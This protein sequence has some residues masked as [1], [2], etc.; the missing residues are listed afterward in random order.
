VK[1]LV[2]H[3]PQEYKVRSTYRTRR[4][5]RTA[6]K[7]SCVCSLEIG[8][9][10]IIALVGDL[11]E[12]G[13]ISI[14]GKGECALVGLAAGK[15]SV[16]SFLKETLGSTEEKVQ[17]SIL[18]VHLVWPCENIATCIPQGSIPVL[19][20]IKDPETEKQKALLESIKYHVADVVFS[21]YCSALAV[22]T[23]EQRGKGVIVC[24][25]GGDIVTYAAFA[26]GKLLAVDAFKI[27][28]KADLATIKAIHISA[29]GAG[30]LNSIAGGILLTGEG[31]QTQGL[32]N[33]VESTFGMKSAIGL[34]VGFKGL[35]AALNKPEYAACLGMLR[36]AYT[37]GLSKVTYTSAIKAAIKKIFGRK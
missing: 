14:M 20:S 18:T 4:Q 28:G 10:R 9:S 31:A 27:Q 25:V 7:T 30:I 22:T 16:E 26:Q 24:D 5:K 23:P 34:P 35:D 3:E 15:A 12:D 33:M 13:N 8:T 36:Y 11:Q 17:V 2:M 6:M 21:G 1:S 32:A 37:D 29:E 19:T